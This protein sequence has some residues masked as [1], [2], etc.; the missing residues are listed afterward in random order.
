[1]A[2]EEKIVSGFC[3]K[4]ALTVGIYPVK[5]KR[6]GKSKYVYVVP[7]DGSNE[8]QYQLMLG[9]NFFE[10]KAAAELKAVEMASKRLESL[11]KERKKLEDLL[12]RPKWRDG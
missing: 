1:M 5:V 3:T 6:T 4:Y 11:N 9:T 10:G 2:D 8:W 7:E 12:E